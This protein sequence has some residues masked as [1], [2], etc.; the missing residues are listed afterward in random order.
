MDLSKNNLKKLLWITPAIA[1]FLIALIP[2]LQYQWPLSWDIINHVLYAKIYAQYGLT[3]TNPFLNAPYG[4]KIGYP[5]LFDL[6]LA[7]LGTVSGV[8]YFQV[9][10]FL[11]PLMAISV[12]LSVSYVG[13]RFYGAV[14]GAGAGFLMLSSYLMGRLILSIP[15]NL[16]L[17]F[18]PLAVYLYYRS[19]QDKRLRTAFFSGILLFIIISTHQAAALCL[20]LIISS[21]TLFEILYHQKLGVLKNYAT[22]YGFS[23][24]IMAF[25][26]VTILILSPQILQE[27]LNQGFSS[28]TG[29]A[30]SLSQ[31]RALS[32]GGYMRNIGPIVLMFSLLG[33]IMALKKRSRK[34]NVVLVWILTMFLLSNAY[35][36]GVNVITYRVLI[37]LLIPLSIIGGFGL[38]YLHQK[39]KDY[40]QLSSKE[41]RTAFLVAMF[42][43]SIFSGVLNVEN[44]KIAQFK[45]KNQFE[46]IKI[47]PPSDSELDLA[48]WFQENG[49][50]S[51]SL[52]ISNL[53]TGTF[54]AAET[55]MPL[56][57][58][59]ELYSIKNG[60]DANIAAM[61]KE[62][63]GYIIYDKRLVL[64][65][66][67]NSLYILR[68][69]SEFYPMY[70]LS[71]DIRSHIQDIKP[72]YT[73]IVYENQDFIVLQIIFPD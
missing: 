51:R 45:V 58:N 65:P 6:L 22:F 11:Q 44:P 72:N 70:Y 4:Q 47:G 35:W 3:L 34:N 39:L 15:E 55:G 40:E 1:A 10:R 20:L 31:T 68:V 42:A 28:A 52:V 23:A 14:A 41:F 73:R 17:I 25:G 5:P 59:F 26:F 46:E 63:I 54:L 49:N 62:G 37:Y 13:K 24:I 18:L 9:A 64:S 66:P 29:M 48:R 21:I 16:A 8:D 69:D 61:K 38:S 30:T 50:R 57:Y 2:T 53:F 7:G 32:I 19:L 27:I 67:D 71:Q 43:L 56:H 36:F 60:T 12:V 33:I